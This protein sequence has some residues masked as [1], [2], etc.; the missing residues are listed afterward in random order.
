MQK[1]FSMKRIL[2]TFLAFS[3]ISK[4][5][6]NEKYLHINDD[7]HQPVPFASVYI[8]ELNK[9]FLANQKGQVS[10]TNVQPGRYSIQISMMGYTP[11]EKGIEIDEDT[12][13]HDLVISKTSQSLK[14]IEVFGDKE[15]Q[16][17]KLDA[18]TRLPLAPNAQIQAISIISEKVIQD[19]GALTIADVTRNVPGVYTF[20]TYGNQRESMSMRGFRGVP[21]LKNGVRI[22]SDFRGTGM[23]TDMQGVENI[24]VLKGASAISQGVATDIGSPGGVINIVTKTPQFEN[25]GTVSMR[26]GSWQQFRPAFDVQQVLNKDYTL[27]FR[28]NGVYEHSLS[29]RPGIQ[30][31]K[32]YVNPSLAWKPSEKTTIIFELDYLNDERTPDPGTIN[33]ASNDINAIYQI[34]YDYFPGFKEQRNITNNLTYAARIQHDIFDQFEF[35]AAFYGSRLNTDGISTTFIQKNSFLP[36]LGF[37]ERYRTIGSATRADNNHV[38]QLDF[39]GKEI[40]TGALRH[41]VMVGADFRTSQLMTQAGAMKAGHFLDVIDFT[42]PF[43]HSYPNKGQKYVAAI[44]DEQGNVIEEGHFTEAPIG[45]DLEEAIY[46]SQSSY[47]VLLQDVISYHDWLK[48]Y[49]GGRFSSLTSKT[50]VDPTSFLTGSAFDPHVGVMIHP[51]K[52]L[53]IFGSFTTS[54]SLSG[55][56]NIDTL[57]NAL[58]NQTITQWEAGIKSDWLDKR[59]RVNVTAYLINNKNMSIPVYD[60]QWNPT[61]FFTKGGNDERKG[62]EV[63][64]LGRVLESLEVVAG[65]AYIDAQYKSHASYYE[66]SAPLNTPKHTA[67]GWI[68]YGFSERIMKGL[69]LAA[70]IY[71]IGERPVN[72]WGVVVT[73]EGMVAGQKPFMIEAVSTLNAQIGYTYKSWGINLVANNILNKIGYNAYR[74]SFIN[75]TDPRSFALILNY[76]F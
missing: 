20:S 39:I 15:T 42:Q 48:I 17:D 67:N 68:K 19:Q 22:N 25:R 59:L 11:I 43:G 55:A 57:G 63:E 10:L 2:Y 29:Y 4:T 49:F 34:P 24:Q 52:P 73:H 70:G 26:Y 71:Y 38:L 31:E 61:G 12:K 45:I 74:T 18:L 75:Q 8:K 58:G 6:G 13:I 21:I 62:I 51:I 3:L 40:R 7:H 44:K 27:A 60:A 69:S 41:T 50:S 33:R 46:S 37:N 47:G 28:M 66:G 30:L 1:T 65:Y 54:T 14:A 53:Q 16:A 64:V 35:R 56:T 5:F 9:T 23:L 36:G 72:D 32:I 76:N